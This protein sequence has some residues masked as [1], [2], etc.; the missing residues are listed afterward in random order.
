MN[1]NVRPDA[2]SACA[3]SGPGSVN[4][5]GGGG[6]REAERGSRA[7]RGRRAGMVSAIHRI[8]ASQRAQKAPHR[9]SDRPSTGAAPVEWALRLMS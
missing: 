5:H 3:L 6:V 2:S 8:L 7:P 9:A 1:K 4:D